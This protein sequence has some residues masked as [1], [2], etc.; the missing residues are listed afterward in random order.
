MNN[1][2]NAATATL[3]ADT[4]TT[5]T[6]P[7]TGTMTDT[8]SPRSS[9]SSSSSKKLQRDGNAKERKEDGDGS[10]N[11]KSESITFPSLERID[12]ADDYKSIQQDNGKTKNNSRDRHGSSRSSRSSSR[13]SGNKNKD[14]NKHKDNGS[15]TVENVSLPPLTPPKQSQSHSLAP[16]LDPPKQEEG[17]PILPNEKK[18]DRRDLSSLLARQERSERGLDKKM[19][20]VQ[21][22]V[23]C[24][25]ALVKSLHVRDPSAAIGR[26]FHELDINKNGILD[27]EEL[28]AFM[29]EAANMI[30]LQISGTIIDD[31]VEA[32]LE[33]V[34]ASE[35]NCIT[36]E[37]FQEIFHRH[38]ELAKC[39]ETE[40]ESPTGNKNDDAE[41]NN[42]NYYA[43]SDMMETS[44]RSY[45]QQLEE[46]EAA[47]IRKKK[48][49][50]WDRACTNWK[51]QKVAYIWTM[52]YLMA[53][54]FAY[55]YKATL[56][57]RRDDATAVFGQCVIVAR[58]SA[59][60]LNLNCAL[61]L[62]PVCRHFMTGLRHYP[63]IKFYFPFDAILS[64]HMVI[65]TAIAFFITLHVGAHMCDC[66]QFARADRE[67][68]I[69]LVGDKLGDDIP[70][71]ISERWMLL[72]RQRA[73][74]TGIIMTVC[75]LIAYPLTLYRRTHFNTFW[76]AHHLLIVMLITLCFHGTGNLLEPYQSVYW[77]IGPLVLYMLPRIWRETP[78]SRCKVLDITIQKGNVIGLKLKRPS[79]WDP[80]LI[81]AGMYAFLNVPKVSCVEWHPF[82]L[83]SCPADD[84]IEFNFARAGDWTRAVHDILE[85]ISIHEDEIEKENLIVKVEGPIG[86]SSQGFSHY[87]VVVLIAAG[88]G[89]TPMISVLKQ[90]LKQPGKMKKTFFYWTVRDR[91]SFEWFNSLMDEIFQNDVDNRIEIRN[92]LT[93]LKDDRR[94]LGSVLFHHSTRVKH[95]KTNYDLISGQ[96]TR[97]RVEVGRPNW[98][99][100]FESVKEIAS[101]ELGYKKCGVFLCGPEKM[102]NAVSKATFRLSKKD[103]NFHFYF[104]KETF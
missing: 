14:K 70:D 74:I 50:V 68:I 38:P 21:S 45:Y 15:S 36:L 42:D 100:E 20:F 78:A 56:Y 84:Y 54:I 33:D 48:T 40:E 2:T 19:S 23:S 1:D 72:M 99:D 62:L 58:G 92:F 18:T 101:T 49:K 87:P 31:A 79:S 91:D 73:V 30:K 6:T 96:F 22:V 44:R 90:L 7:G 13:R 57:S 4:G 64:Y 94:D 46:P 26:A 66:Y 65:G 55:S 97:R 39:F 88:I 98:E 77:L 27:R 75:C 67:D 53:N 29:T 59:Q 24:R 8:T 28:T 63:S 76:A 32:L 83:T 11:N 95:H 80:P 102:G 41:N 81:Q 5:G 82:T 25:E 71:G 89:V 60:C 52:L 61:I 16:A 10:K 35:E 12:H 43:P 103:R 51:S 69:D 37:Q 3:T 85:E 86:A 17:S 9:S 93:S 47:H 104:T 34:G